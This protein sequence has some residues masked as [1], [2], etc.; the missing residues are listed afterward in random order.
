MA[1]NIMAWLVL[2][3]IVGTK[4]LCHRHVGLFRNNMAEVLW[5]QRG[6]SKQ[7]AVVGRLLRVLVLWKQ[8]ARVS[9]VVAAH[10]AG[11]LNVLGDIPS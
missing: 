4:N 8:V 6:A 11:Y 1:G 5:T 9:P 7:S 2:E 3:G 10:V